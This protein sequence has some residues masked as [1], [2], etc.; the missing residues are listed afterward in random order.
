MQSTFEQRFKYLLRRSGYQQ[1]EIA[2]WLPASPSTL[3]RWIKGKRPIPLIQLE[4]ICKDKFELSEKETQELLALV[5]STGLPTGNKEGSKSVHQA[6]IFSPPLVRPPQA[7]NFVGRQEDLAQLINDLQLGEVVTLCG[8][9][10]IGK[11]TLAAQAVWTLAPGN[12]PSERFPDGIFFHSFYNQPQVDFALENIARSFGETLQPTVT[13]AAQRALAGRRALLVLDG[14]EEA[15]DLNKIVGIRNLCGVLVT[16][17]RRADAS[18]KRQDVAPLPLKDAVS[19][20]QA[21]GGKWADDRDSV[22]LICKLVGALP[23]AVRLAGRYLAEQEWEAVEFLEWL[24]E[25]TP[26]AALNQGKRQSESV[27]LL[28][29]SCISQVSRDAQQILSIVGILALSPLRLDSIA[30]A[31]NI[32]PVSARRRMGELVNY[33]ILLRQGERYVVSHALVHT[34]ARQH[35]PPEKKIIGRTIEYT[36]NFVTDNENNFTRLN[37]IR[38]H[39][40]ALL[41]FCEHSQTWRRVNELAKKFDDYLE[42]QGFWSER[43]RVIEI[44]ITSARAVKNRQDESYWLNH[45]GSTYEDLCE[46]EKAIDFCQQALG[47]AQEIDYTYGEAFSWRLLGVV[48]GDIANYE[49]RIECYNQALSKYREIGHARGIGNTFGNLGVAYKDLGNYEKAIE[50]H[51]QALLSAQKRGDRRVEGNNLGNLAVV[52]RHMDQYEQAIEYCNQAIA[53]SQEVGSRDAEGS[54]LGNLGMIY[55]DLE[56][57]GKAIDY[58]LQALDIAQEIGDKRGE[59]IR[60]HMLGYSYL[61]SGERSKSIGYFQRA[62]DIAE[63][64]GNSQGAGDNFC[65]MGDAYNALGKF[66][67]A[68]DYYKQAVAVAQEIDHPRNQGFYL[69]KLGDTYC[70]WGKRE[71]AIDYY[72]QAL[73]VYT[74]IQSPLAESVCQKLNALKSSGIEFG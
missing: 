32:S 70:N 8:P 7:E 27:P 60:I 13:A 28:L 68:I 25:E 55:R 56:E 45:L 6:D 42:V 63:S 43:L 15:D 24:E 5:D 16:S 48:Y 39:V 53:I 19:L 21:W 26:L 49:K 3:S 52:Y 23:L 71:E 73:T 35:L 1:K 51:T 4:R 74:E 29:T 38:P 67:T 31:I 64:I 2:Q 50:Y 36:I 61:E 57:Y 18:A 12:E 22:L 10:G 33:G 9:G 72:Q 34:Y 66:E 47:I 62:L 17:R 11:T 58:S 46:Y 44:A 37:E 40:L 20:L 59:G 41:D 65:G 14:A 54:F 30:D 69:D